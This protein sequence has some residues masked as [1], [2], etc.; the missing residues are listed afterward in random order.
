MLGS[1]ESSVSQE[2]AM[3]C[4]TANKFRIML[5]PLVTGRGTENECFIN[6]FDSWRHT[7]K[8][9]LLLNVFQWT[10]LKLHFASF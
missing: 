10:Q 4:W 7:H 2:H 5:V 8:W 6:S 3:Q 1:A 9:F